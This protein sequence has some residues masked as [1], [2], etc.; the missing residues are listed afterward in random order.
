MV[1]VCAAFASRQL[2]RS[3]RNRLL[4]ISRRGFLASAFP[5]AAPESTTSSVETVET[6]S[7][8]KVSFRPPPVKRGSLASGSIF[9]DGED[10][11]EITTSRR[12][13]RRRPE[14]VEAAEEG[15]AEP[16]LPALNERDAAN[17]ERTLN[18]FP[19]RRARW[20]RKMIIRTVRRRGRLTRREQIMQSERDL[21][22]KSHW[23][24]TSVKKLGPLARQIAGKNIDEAILQM[25]FSKKKAARDVKAFLEHAKHEAIVARGMGFGQLQAQAE[26][27]T[28]ETAEGEE[29]VKTTAITPRNN[30]KPV[31]LRLKDGR[32]LSITDPTSIYVAQAWVNRGPYGTEPSHRARGNIHILRPPY[33][34]LSVVLKEEKTRIREWQ[35]REER[36]IRY[37]RK[38]V[39]TQLPDRKVTIRNQY[40]A[41]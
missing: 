25:R 32:Y 29:Q 8:P 40:Y 2:A 6:K 37:R 13:P 14:T 18:P 33:T 39:W 30:A 11:P 10:P 41:W 24:K 12:T 15:E 26:S 35:E 16:R 28:G 1:G 20:Q 23:F 22:S 3:A 38:K 31:T 4:Q 5:N 34:S 17:L 7:G 19:N 21:T 36:L 27:A 9:A